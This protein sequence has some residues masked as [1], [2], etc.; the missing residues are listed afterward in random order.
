MAY[1]VAC[2]SLVNK[3]KYTAIYTVLIFLLLVHTAIKD[4]DLELLDLE[5]ALDLK[6]VT[7]TSLGLKAVAGVEQ[8]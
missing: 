4:L 6:L 3:G 2:S 7:W 8:V 1:S 5:L